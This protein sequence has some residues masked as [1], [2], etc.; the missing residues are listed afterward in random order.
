MRIHIHRH[1]Q[2]FDEIDDQVQ[3]AVD[4]PSIIPQAANPQTGL[5]PQI[6]IVD[7]GNCHIKPVMNFVFYTL[8]DLT[9]FFQRV[10]L[11]QIKNYFQDP[12][13]HKNP[14]KR[15]QGTRCKVQGKP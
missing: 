13:D 3:A 7:L 5:L 4:L 6:L 14:K 10:R 15:V 8:D 9:L 12:D 11:R 1:L 2:A